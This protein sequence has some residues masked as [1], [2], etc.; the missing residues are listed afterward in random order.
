[1]SIEQKQP[2]RGRTDESDPTY[3]ELRA[4]KAAFAFGNFSA[5]AKELGLKPATV[6]G[7]VASLAKKVKLAYDTDLYRY[8]ASE[9][10]ISPTKI[11]T[12]L[13]E[14]AMDAVRAVEGAGGLMREEL[15]D[16][17]VRA[18]ATLGLWDE[19]ILPALV[20]VRERLGNFR[21]EMLGRGSLRAIEAVRRNRCHVGFAAGDVLKRYRLPDEL[22]S[23]PCKER[24]RVQLIVPTR[25]TLASDGEFEEALA[26]A[27]NGDK[28]GARKVLATIGAAGQLIVPFKGSSFRQGV[29]RTFRRHRVKLPEIQAFDTSYIILSA[30]SHGWGITIQQ[31]IPN[32]TGYEQRIKRIDLTGVFPDWPEVAVWY[33]RYLTAPARA[34][35]ER[36]CG[37]EL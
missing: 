10:R 3:S 16:D 5:A 23:H 22:V 21:I 36:L 14:F 19:W 27:R 33:P 12:E 34:L 4:L 24:L 37:T 26:V 31:H 32:K 25:H 13:Y 1:M 29:E 15:R 7:L 35:I 8:D 20:E 28:K 11:G 6:Q 2:T 9:R 18:A 30:V 17:V